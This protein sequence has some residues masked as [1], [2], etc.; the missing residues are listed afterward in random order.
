MEIKQ[1]ILKT[2]RDSKEPLKCGE[3]AEKCG[4]DKEAVDKAIKVLVKEN[5]VTSPKRCYYQAK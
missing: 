1:I 4:Q 3:V 5:L 2:L